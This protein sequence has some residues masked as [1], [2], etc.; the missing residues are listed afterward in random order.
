M[1]GA[2]TFPSTT[3]SRILSFAQDPSLQDPMTKPL[4]IHCPYHSP[5]DVGFTGLHIL[6]TAQVVERN[7]AWAYLSQVYA[8]KG[9]TKSPL[10]A[11]ANAY[12]F[13]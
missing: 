13:S 11:F 8:T 9:N 4:C 2:C 10:A 12:P 7:A 1:V 6:S 3:L 5:G